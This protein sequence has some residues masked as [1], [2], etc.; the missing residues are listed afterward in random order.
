MLL[1]FQHGEKWI[2]VGA[3]LCFSY[4]LSLRVPEVFIFEIGLMQKHKEI[5]NVLV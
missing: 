2:M 5:K 3:Y 1:D 4:V